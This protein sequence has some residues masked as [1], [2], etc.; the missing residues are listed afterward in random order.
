MAGRRRS[1][2][3]Q[4]PLENRALPPWGFTPAHPHTLTPSRTQKLTQSHTHTLTHPHPHTL[5]TWLA[6]LDSSEAM[7][8]P[9]T[10]GVSV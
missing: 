1:K 8:L 4:D 10:F 2:P 7:R 9:T 5:G 3:H 6:S